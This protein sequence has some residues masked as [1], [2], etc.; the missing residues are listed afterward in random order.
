MTSLT[1]G[2]GSLTGAGSMPC[3]GCAGSADAGVAAGK[4]WEVPAEVAVIDGLAL[5]PDSLTMVLVEL[6]WMAVG[7][8]V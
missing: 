2:G 3:S 6:F 8:L 1:E 7:R 5:L 4:A